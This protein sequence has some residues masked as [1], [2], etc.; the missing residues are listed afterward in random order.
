MGLSLAGELAEMYA[1]SDNFS[2]IDPIRQIGVIYALSWF[3]VRFIA[4][5]ER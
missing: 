3:I 1:E 5:A 4:Q 2:L